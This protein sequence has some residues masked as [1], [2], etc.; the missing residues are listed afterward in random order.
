MAVSA[1]ILSFIFL[2]GRHLFRGVR[3]DLMQGREGSVRDEII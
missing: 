1:L 3:A 2:G